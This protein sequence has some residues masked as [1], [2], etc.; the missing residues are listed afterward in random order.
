MSALFQKFVDW[1]I[2]S[3]WFKKY[4]ATF[5]GVALGI[6]L[7]SNYGNLIAATLTIWGIGDTAWNYSL[8]A[9]IGASAL[10]V[11]IAGSLVKSSQIKTAAKVDAAVQDERVA[12]AVGIVTPP[13]TIKLKPPA[14]IEHRPGDPML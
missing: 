14:D 11:S 9:V 4:S 10:G 2:S 7:Q 3:T 12:V 5:G 13:D 1:T 8:L 6:W